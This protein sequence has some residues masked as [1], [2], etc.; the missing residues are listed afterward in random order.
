MHFDRIDLR[1][2]SSS[3]EAVQGGAIKVKGIGAHVGLYTYHDEKGAPFIELV[4]RSTLFDPASLE[5]VAGT[6]VTMRHPAGL[7]TSDNWRDTSHG[8][9]LDAW[10]SGDDLGVSL[11]VKSPEAV[12]MVRDAAERGIPIELSPGYEVDVVDAPGETEF[13]RH[14]AI[15]QQRVYNHIALLGPG[16]ARGGPQMRLQ[17]DGPVCAPAGCRVQLARVLRT[18][19]RT[20]TPMK[21]TVSHKDGRTVTLDGAAF[22][23]LRPGAV[24]CDAIETAQVTVTREGEEPIELMLPVGMVEMM[25][26]GIGAEGAAPAAPAGMEEEEMVEVVDADEDEPK[27][28]AN[29]RAYIDSQISKRYAALRAKERQ[30]DARYAEVSKHASALKVDSVDGRSW[31]QIALDGIAKHDPTRTDAAKA[32]VSKVLKGDAVAEGMLRQMLADAARTVD[33]H[34]DM[35]PGKKIKKKADTSSAAPARAPWELGQSNQK[36]AN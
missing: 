22:G 35:A 24:K 2:D 27:M 3:I 9:W 17:L 25:L 18:D 21:I 15:Q 28:D 19:A 12:A 31:T 13:G 34:G 33:I 30:A 29:T 11:L 20:E 6:D 10:P 1:L 5:T 32:L 8:V 16:E 14:D 36:A 26:A 23:W 4:P 7:V